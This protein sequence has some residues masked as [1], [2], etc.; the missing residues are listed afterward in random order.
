MIDSHDGADHGKTNKNVTNIVS[1]SSKLVSQKSLD[2]GY[3]GGTSL[4]ILTW[5]Q[6][7][8]EEKPINIFPAVNDY[9]LEKYKRIQNMTVDEKKKNTFL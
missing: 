6:M 3:G 9:L 5:Q 2:G 7:R 4:D 8:G 1:F